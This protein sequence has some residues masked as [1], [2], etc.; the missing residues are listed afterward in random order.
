M[1]LYFILHQDKSEEE[2]SALQSFL[3]EEAAAGRE[4]SYLVVTD[5]TVLCSLCSELRIPAVGVAPKKEILFDLEFD[6]GSIPKAL[7]LVADP[8]QVEDE[9][10]YRM[11]KRLRGESLIAGE[12]KR[13][14]LRESKIEDA[15]PL[16]ELFASVTKADGTKVP[17]TDAEAGRSFLKDYIQNQYAVMEFGIWSVIEKKSGAVIGWAGLSLWGESGHEECEDGYNLSYGIRPAYRGKGFATEV[18]AEIL[19]IGFEEYGMER[20]D[21]EVLPSNEASLAVGQNLAASGRFTCHSDTAPEKTVF[22]F[23]KTET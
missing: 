10:Y 23:Y 14:I 1:K 13:C 20:I 18:G 21:C 16:T 15:E 2:I 17:F 5:D 4:K 8:E 6:A 22:R 9:D 3:R 12:T 7:Y 19:R 11:W